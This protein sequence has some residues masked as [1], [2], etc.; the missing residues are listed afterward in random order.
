MS[1]TGS[2][3]LKAVRGCA[4]PAWCWR[5]AKRRHSVLELAYALAF[6]TFGLTDF[7]EAQ[8]L[9]SW[10]IWL[11]LLNLIVLL[12]LRAV[13]IKRYYPLCKLY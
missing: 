5:Y 9:T 4:S 13:V 12:R 10:L 6:F 2:I 3:S 11:K 1:I 8:A 7:Q